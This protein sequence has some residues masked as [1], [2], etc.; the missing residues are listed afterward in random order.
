MNRQT[1]IGLTGLLAVGLMA[2]TL[3]GNEPPIRKFIDA[4]N[5]D[6]NVRPGD[7][8]YEYANGKWL[9]TNPVPASKT[10]WGSFDVLRDKSLDAIKTLLTEAAKAPRT[11]PQ[12]LVG[13]FYASGMDSVLIEKLGFDPVRPELNRIDQLASKAALL[14][15]MAYLRTRG[16]GMLFGFGVSPDRK[17][18]T[19]YLPQFGQGGL[20]LPDRDYYLKS[21]ARSRRIRDAFRENVTAMF[22]LVGEEPTRASQNADL[23]MRFETLQDL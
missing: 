15:E 21:D 22:G 19:K 20:T 7:N 17:N 4:A 16:R 13:D 10:R 12:Q 18:V 14:D 6:M 1:S 23:I 5:M 2:F 8:F 9:A 3:P 11:R